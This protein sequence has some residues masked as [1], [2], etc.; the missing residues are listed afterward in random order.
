MA[1]GHELLQQLLHR[2]IFPSPYGLFRMGFQN[3]REIVKNH[4]NVNV[5]DKNFVIATFF[6]DYLHTDN[7]RCRSAHNSYTWR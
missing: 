5:C 4:M 6:R 7:S 2:G 1:K 3:F